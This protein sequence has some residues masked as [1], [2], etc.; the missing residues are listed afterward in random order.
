MK[1]ENLW[2]VEEARLPKVLSSGSVLIFQGL[3]GLCV[4]G[5]ICT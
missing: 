5:M 2:F 3:D 1:A 4:F